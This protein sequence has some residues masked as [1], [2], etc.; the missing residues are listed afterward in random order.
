MLMTGNP[1]APPKAR[2]E[3]VLPLQAERSRPRQIVTAVQLAAMNYVLGI[4]TI[5]LTWDYMSKFGSP[6]YIIANQVFSLA[7]LVWL[8]YKIYM[9]RNW[10]RV[11]MLVMWLVGMLMG[12]GMMFSD[13]L[14]ES[15]VIARVQ[16]FISF[17]ISLVIQWL[18]FFSPGRVWF[19][20]QMTVVRAPA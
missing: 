13:V 6:A 16:T 4:A 3:D 11:T 1:Y 9:G 20:R 14:P 15:P 18:L 7:L 5:P 10:A 19:Q 2:V 17:G 8:Y 12:V